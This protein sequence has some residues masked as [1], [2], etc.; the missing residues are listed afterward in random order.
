MMSLKSSREQNKKVSSDIEKS[1]NPKVT[2]INICLIIVFTVLIAITIAV[3]IRSLDAPLERDE[4]EYAYAGQLMLEGVMP[5]SQAYNMKMPGIYAA[6]AVIL[7]CFG[8][9]PAGVHIG[10]M[11]VNLATIILLFFLAKK[12]FGPIAGVA[13]AVFFAITSVSSKINA[14][15]NAENFV[16]LAAVAG[17][18]LVVSFADTKKFISLI[19]GAFLLGIGFMMKQH[20]AGFIIFGFLLLLW[21]QIRQKPL[22]WKRLVLIELVYGVFVVLPFLITCLVLW[23]CGVFEKFWFWTFE[24]ASKYT[25]M[26]PLKQ[27]FAMLKDTLRLIVPPVHWIWLLGLLGLLSIIWDKRIRGHSAFLVGFTACSFLAVCP[28]L[29]FRA[30]YFVLFLPAL[31][32]LAA[33]GIAAVYDLAGSHVKSNTAAGI[34]SILVVLIIWGQ[35][36]YDQKDYL[37]ESNADKISRH[38]F[39]LCPFPEILE[40]ARFIKAN[41]SRDD[42]IA[43]LG[44][45]PQIFFYSQR[46][47]ATPYIYMYPLME[48]QLYAADMQRE[49]IR[50]IEA[51]RPK[52]I[53]SMN[54]VDSWLVQ[55]DS[56]RLVFNWMREYIPANYRQIGL[57]ETF[58]LDNTSYNWDSTTKPLK[59]DDWIFIGVRKD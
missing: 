8:Q 26:V 51:D 57:V 4:G 21:R 42:K 14:T 10:V 18:M 29:F 23:R 50:Q 24:Y 27:G 25:G 28:G 54:F 31:S 43:V 58:S 49:M 15:A 55:K 59:K 33:A 30:H 1:S 35:S 11:I 37:T 6:Y 45:E 53:V 9:S 16:I 38:N 47:S 34:I 40:I 56:E 5:Y 13:C 17:I 52:F 48:P 39:G 22:N 44:S 2:L 46:H 41:S 3:R 20:G 32:L 36:F 12:L 19:A 7:A